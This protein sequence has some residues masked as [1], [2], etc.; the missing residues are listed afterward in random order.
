[1]GGYYEK[2]SVNQKENMDTLSVYVK[3]ERKEMRM[4]KSFLLNPIEWDGLSLEKKEAICHDLF[5]DMVDWKWE[6]RKSVNRG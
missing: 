5:W 6:E 3:Q 2:S 1:M 4:V